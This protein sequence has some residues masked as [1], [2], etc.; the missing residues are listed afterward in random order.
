MQNVTNKLR[1][2][3]FHSHNILWTNG[4]KHMSTL[5]IT[6]YM[7]FKRCVFLVNTLKMSLTCGKS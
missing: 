4:L 1:S 3:F 6:F 2:F 5:L 7:F